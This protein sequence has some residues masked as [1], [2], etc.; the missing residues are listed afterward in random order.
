MSDHWN[1]Q[2]LWS[3]GMKK[4]TKT[5]PELESFI[6]DQLKLYLSGSNHLDCPA[7]LKQPRNF[8]LSL[9]VPYL[10]LYGFLGSVDNDKWQVSTLQRIQLIRESGE[11][12]P[13]SYSAFVPY[14]SAQYR[15]TWPTMAPAGLS[16]TTS[17]LPV[18]NPI[19][20]PRF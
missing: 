5:D 14:P 18:S 11:E 13:I 20:N 6:Q 17:T 16:A 1:V 9:L 3:S 12:V 15:V 10:K 19:P 4:S 8:Q 2:L 7:Y